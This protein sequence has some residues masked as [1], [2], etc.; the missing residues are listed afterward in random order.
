[1][2]HACG[3]CLVDFVN[4]EPPER[5][6]D[7]VGSRRRSIL[8]WARPFCRRLNSV[9]VTMTAGT[10]RSGVNVRLKLG[11]VNWRG[12]LPWSKGPLHPPFG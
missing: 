1:M 8:A 2:L 11:I 12:P 6:V 3:Q 9:Q 7:L 10:S 4:K 5:I